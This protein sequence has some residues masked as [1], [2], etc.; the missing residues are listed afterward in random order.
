M[1]CLTKKH[2]KLNPETVQAITFLKDNYKY[3][4]KDATETDSQATSIDDPENDSEA[5]SEED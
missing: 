4:P 2:N 5:D 3:F 1:L